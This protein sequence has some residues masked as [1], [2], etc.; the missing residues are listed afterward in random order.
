MAHPTQT[1][2]CR[3]CR[4]PVECAGPTAT[5]D[6]SDMLISRKSKKHPD[7]SSCPKC[8]LVQVS[9]LLSP[10]DLGKLYEGVEDPAVERETTG[11]ASSFRRDI[12]RLRQ[13]AGEPKAVLEIGAFTGIAGAVLREDIPGA[14][15]LGIEPSRWA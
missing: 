3:L 7:M 4:E 14:D 8:G 5:V 13:M 2:R 11:R 12:R 15:F 6:G 10:T 9:G 1:F